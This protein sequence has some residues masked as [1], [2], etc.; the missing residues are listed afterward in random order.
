MHAGMMGKMSNAALRFTAVV[1]VAQYALT[2]P[3]SA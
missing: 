3:L 1:H 2:D